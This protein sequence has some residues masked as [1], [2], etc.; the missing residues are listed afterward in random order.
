MIGNSGK[1]K[2]RKKQIAIQQKRNNHMK[3]MKYNDEVRKHMAKTMCDLEDAWNHVQ[4]S[5]VYDTEVIQR[6]IEKSK[7]S[8]DKLMCLLKDICLG[9][10]CEFETTRS[11]PSVNVRVCKNCGKKEEMSSW[12]EY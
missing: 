2:Q 5:L 12:A 1:T 11:M 6:R 3:I 9:H 4:W 10:K 7:D 8:I